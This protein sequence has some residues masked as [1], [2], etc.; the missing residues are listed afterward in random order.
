MQKITLF[1]F[2]LFIDSSNAMFLTV[3]STHPSDKFEDVFTKLPQPS[4]E[5]ACLYLA[6]FAHDDAGAD[7][8][9]WFMVESLV[10]H[11][12]DETYDYLKETTLS[13]IDPKACF[14]ESRSELKKIFNRQKEANEARN[15]AP[16]SFFYDSLIALCAWLKS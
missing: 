15:A 10:N 13:Y 1:I 5:E 11:Y 3:D 9:L 2:L 4:P 6:A 7:R 16:Q 8:G 12:P 14:D